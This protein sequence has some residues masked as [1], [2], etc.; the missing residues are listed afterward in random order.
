MAA[1]DSSGAGVVFDRRKLDLDGEG[2]VVE[3][4]LAAELRRQEE[5]YK[6]RLIGVRVHN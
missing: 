3:E 5:L 4:G 6:V 2:G 1:T